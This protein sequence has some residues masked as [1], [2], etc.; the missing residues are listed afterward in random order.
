MR[1][2][3]YLKIPTAD[4][5]KTF[6]NLGYILSPCRHFLASAHDKK[7]SNDLEARK[8]QGSLIFVCTIQ[9]QRHYTQIAYLT[10]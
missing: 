8:Q 6:D 2:L 10:S 4:S 9:R 3:L 5:S 1:A 7:V